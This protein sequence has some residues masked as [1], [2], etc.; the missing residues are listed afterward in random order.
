MGK[1]LYEALYW[2][3]KFINYFEQDYN[4]WLEESREMMELPDD[5]LNEEEKMIKREQKKFMTSMFNHH[6]PDI[7]E[8]ILIY[9]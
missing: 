4:L 3:N 7:I 9:T 1:G 8:I 5:K 2:L 6:F